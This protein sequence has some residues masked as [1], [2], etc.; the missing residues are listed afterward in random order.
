MMEAAAADIEDIYDP[1]GYVLRAAWDGTDWLS[2]TVVQGGEASWHPN[3]PPAVD[4]DNDGF[5]DNLVR[6][7]IQSGRCSDAMMSGLTDCLLS[8]VRCKSY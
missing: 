2:S 5:S 7:S 4:A 8:N 6:V 3:L 1:E